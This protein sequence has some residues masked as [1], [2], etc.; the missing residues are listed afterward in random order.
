MTEKEIKLLGF[1]R[2]D[3]KDGNYSGYYYSYDIAHGFSFI[4]NANDEIEE[5]G[6]WFVEFFNSDPQILFYEFGEV[7]ALIN[8]IEKRVVKKEEKVENIFRILK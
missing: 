3:M 1:K 2:E 6:S 7:Q 4:S 8:L 5:D